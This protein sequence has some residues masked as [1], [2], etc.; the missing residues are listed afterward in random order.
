ME[1]S[2]IVGTTKKTWLEP[3]AGRVGRRY[4]PE[5]EPKLTHIHDLCHKLWRRG[6]PVQRPL[7]PLTRDADGHLIAYYTYEQDD[8]PDEYKDGWYS[9]RITPTRQRNAAAVFAA[10]QRAALDL[11]GPEQPLDYP[12]CNTLHW[13]QAHASVEALLGPWADSQ[14][15]GV[16]ELL[17]EFAGLIE[18]LMA[19]A[20]PIIDQS[21]WGLCHGDYHSGNTIFR[22]DRLV[23]VVDFG[24]WL[25]HP[26]VFDL[27]IAVEFWGQDW[28]SETFRLNPASVREFLQTYTEARGP[29]AIPPRL[30]AVSAI[31]RLWIDTYTIRDSVYPDGEAP[32]VRRMQRFVL[33][34]LRWYAEHVEEGPFL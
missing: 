15:A 16:K 13:T 27:A 5:M 34:R 12:F 29:L 14:K 31:A 4:A 20:Q 21:P 10:F 19:L 17:T 24:F 18:N 26:L 11:H 28:D 33:P 9:P 6:V 7:G 22:G 2:K 1:G 25:H 23:Q 8:G 3:A 30:L 32:L